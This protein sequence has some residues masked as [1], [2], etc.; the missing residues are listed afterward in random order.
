MRR[1]LHHYADR[2]RGELLTNYTTRLRI[3]AFNNSWYALQR[4][5]QRDDVHPSAVCKVHERSYVHQHRKTN[6]HR[7]QSR[8]G[9]TVSSSPAGINCGAA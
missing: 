2:R 8:T 3:D 5:H 6:A 4:R 7:Q 9:R 1:H